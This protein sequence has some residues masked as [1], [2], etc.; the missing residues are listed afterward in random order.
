[1][2]VDNF[3][4]SSLKSIAMFIKQFFIVSLSLP[5]LTLQ[6]QKNFTYTPEKPRPGDVIHFTYEPAGDIA[7]T[8]RPV[9]AVVYQVGKPGNKADDIAMERKAEKYT[10]TIKT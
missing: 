7:N 2:S 9:E 5:G 6:A 3:N 4:F 8:I 10:G 1:M